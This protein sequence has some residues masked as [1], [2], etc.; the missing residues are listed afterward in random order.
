[1]KRLIIFLFCVVLLAS[2]TNMPLPDER[3]VEPVA[4][5]GGL[6]N[7]LAANASGVYTVGKSTNSAIDTVTRKLS[8]SGSP[9]WSRTSNQGYAGTLAVDT[10]GDS[11][12]FR[13]Y[14]ITGVGGIV[15]ERGL[16]LLKYTNSGVL[17]WTL[18]FGKLKSV[19]DP[20]TGTPIGS[21]SES[22]SHV[23]VDAVGNVY[24]LSDY[25]DASFNLVGKYL[26]RKFD[27]TGKLLITFAADKLASQV[28]DSFEFA[29][30]LQLDKAGSVYILTSFYSE[31]TRGTDLSVIKFDATG[32][33]LWKRPVYTALYNGVLRLLSGSFA[34]DSSGN[35]YIAV[36]LATCTD[37]DNLICGDP[38]LFLRKL[39]NGTGHLW[40][41]SV[42][43]RSGGVPLVAVDSEDNIY[44]ASAVSNTAASTSQLLVAKYDGNRNKKW[45]KE[46]PTQP[47]VI[48]LAGLVITDGVYVA[49]RGDMSSSITKFNKLT[50]Q[51]IW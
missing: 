31:A 41:I 48:T 14:Q 34:L 25:R 28:G 1:M 19:I 18:K 11:Y 36:S 39:Q 43:N 6:I 26:V 10:A 24:A 12:V 27:P 4:V 47:G 7:D 40:T 51:V 50:G 9:I 33:F 49:T 46:T 29:S 13:E 22:P 35:L 20:Q 21:I 37:A 38:K 8:L 3:L 23:R 42:D 45:L 17:S 2:C 30:G 16:N 44:F 15:T 5:A 32:K